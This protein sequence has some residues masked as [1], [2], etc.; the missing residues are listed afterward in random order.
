M[1][2]IHQIE[3]NPRGLYCG[4]TLLMFEKFCGMNI[5]IR[6]AD[7]SLLDRHLKV[8]AGGGLTLRSKSS[9]EFLEMKA[10]VESFLTLFL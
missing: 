2:Y 6:T 8:G 1:E 3:S 9:D 7:I 4:S 10:K 5:N